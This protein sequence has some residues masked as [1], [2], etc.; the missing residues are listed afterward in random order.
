[1]KNACVQLV[2]T[3]VTDCLRLKENRLFLD[4]KQPFSS[5]F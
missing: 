1:M 2:A 3:L 4:N 5:F